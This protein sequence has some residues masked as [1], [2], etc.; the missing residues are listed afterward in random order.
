MS[1]HLKWPLTLLGSCKRTIGEGLSDDLHPD[2]NDQSG[3]P[4]NRLRRAIK[5]RII[6]NIALTTGNYDLIEEVQTQED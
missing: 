3:Q 1:E 5:Q 4:H 2:K 6:I